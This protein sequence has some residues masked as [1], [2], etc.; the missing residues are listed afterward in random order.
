MPIAERFSAALA[1]V[2]AP[3]LAAPELLPVRLSRA[4]ARVLAVD[5]AGLSMSDASGRRVPLG[6]SSAAAS[7]AE[8]MQFTA[9]E[10]PCVASQRTGQP[11]FAAEEDLRRRWPM[12]ATLFLGG[13]PYRGVV[14]LPLR[15][16]PSGGGALD[17]YVTRGD[18]VAELDVFDAVAVG[19]LISSALA[20][21]AM[22]STWS[23]AEGP[24]WLHG[25]A[26]RQRAAVWEAVGKI[27]VALDIGSAEALA[28]LRVDAYAAG[29]SVDEVAADLLAGRRPLEELRADRPPGP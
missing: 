5:G 2:S 3:A 9:G 12:F 15:S 10:G 25:P 29:R 6:A 21:A 13:T 16:P 28:L 18:A 26:P 23:P 8:Q 24:D 17:L 22:W 4:C 20:E 19:E 11:V 27:G 7:T 14:A 1:A